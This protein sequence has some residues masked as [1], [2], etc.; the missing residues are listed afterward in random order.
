MIRGV[1]SID[2]AILVPDNFVDFIRLKGHGALG[3]PLWAS[4][5]ATDRYKRLGDGPLEA[6][7]SRDSPLSVGLGLILELFIML[8]FPLG[9]ITV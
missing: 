3:L 8:F 9:R 4:H 7:I 5:I 6:G 2:F 1:S